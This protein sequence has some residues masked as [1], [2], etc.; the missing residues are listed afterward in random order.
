MRCLTQSRYLLVRFG[1]TWHYFHRR[2]F[3]RSCR[4][5]VGRWHDGRW[6]QTEPV[7]RCERHSYCVNDDCNT[8][9]NISFYFN[10]VLVFTSKIPSNDKG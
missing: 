10:L 4:R 9:E 7:L 8:I 5:H 1:R 3:A 6:Q 2:L